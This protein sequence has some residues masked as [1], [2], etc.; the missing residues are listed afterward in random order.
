MSTHIEVSDGL[1]IA[2]V[3]GPRRDVVQL[4]RE[5]ALRVGLA[6]IGMAAEPPVGER[7]EAAA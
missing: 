2:I 3:E 1:R 7:K 4:D 6:L 5:S